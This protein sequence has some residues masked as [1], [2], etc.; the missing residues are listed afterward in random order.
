MDELKYLSIG[1]VSSIRTNARPI[2]KRRILP[3][4]TK[5]KIDQ[6]CT[7]LEKFLKN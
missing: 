2:F 1:F 6:N 5:C 7:K 4:L 3:E